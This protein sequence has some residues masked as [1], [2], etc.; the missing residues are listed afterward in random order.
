MRWS[1][2]A[3][4]MAEGMWCGKGRKMKYVLMR[5][6]ALRAPGTLSSKRPQKT[7]DPHLRISPLENVM[8]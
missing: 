1:Q 6:L 8:R 2:E 3:Q 5:E 7:W 4:M